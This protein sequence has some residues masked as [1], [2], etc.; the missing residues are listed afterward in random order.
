MK[1]AKAEHLTKITKEIVISL[2]KESNNSQDDGTG[3]VSSVK[4]VLEGMK[5]YLEAQ[6]KSLEFKKFF[7]N[8]YSFSKNI[9][10]ESIIKNR[11]KEPDGSL[12]EK[13]TLY[14]DYCFEHIYKKGNFP[15]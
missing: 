12:A 6:G 2:C 14:Y 3:Y 8:L 4:S 5:S 9:W 13:E 1:K 15:L 10:I 11:L 7:E